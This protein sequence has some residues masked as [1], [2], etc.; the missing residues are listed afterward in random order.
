MVLPVDASASD[1]VSK[2]TI[3][4]TFPNGTLLKILIAE[5]QGPPQPLLQADWVRLVSYPATGTFTSSVFDATRTAT[6]GTAS[7]TANAPAGTTVTIQVRSGNTATPDGTWSAWTTVSN[8]GAVSSPAARYL[9]YQ[10]T[11]TTNDPALTPTLNTITF[12]WS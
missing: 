5:Y 2:V 10:V 8:G 4:A 3:S 6:W 1:G 9:Q 12:L 7:W 11:F